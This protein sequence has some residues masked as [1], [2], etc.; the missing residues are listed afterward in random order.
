MVPLLQLM[1]LHWLII[2]IPSPRFTLGFTLGVAHSIG[3]D[4]CAKMYPPLQYHTEQFHCPK[5]PLCSA[6]SSPPPPNPWQPMIFLYLH[7]FAFSRMSNRWN[8]TECSLFKWLLS[9]GNMHLRFLHVSSWLQSSSCFFFYNFSNMRWA[10][11]LPVPHA[12]FR[13]QVSTHVNL[14]PS[15]HLSSI[16]FRTRIQKWENCHKRCT[17]MWLF[18]LKKWV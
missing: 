12:N 10:L 7:S 11:G 5:I 15:F 1:N 6:C 14:P 9:L 4:K 16:Y 8:H 13:S 18:E 2:F 17:L 3:F